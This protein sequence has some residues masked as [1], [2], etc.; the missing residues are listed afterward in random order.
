MIQSQLRANPSS[1][2][3]W[4]ESA[5]SLAGGMDRIAMG[6]LRV[7]LVIVLLWIGGLKFAAYEADSIVPF[8][9][10]SPM[11]R[12][13]YHH[14]NEYRTH[15]NKEGELK[16]QNRT[17]HRENKT[18]PV[19]RG[20]GAVEILIGLAIALFPVKPEISALG[21]ALIILM[22]CATLSFLI[23]T[24]EVWVPSLGD[25]SY[26][27][28]YL[29]GAGRLILKDCIM[30][31]AGFVTLADSAKSYLSGHAFTRRL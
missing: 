31:S 29:S 3:A 17:W 22:S 27:F 8:V 13:L 18:Y 11:M 26:G 4:L 14:P 16:P 12:F 30:L 2:A 9:A 20:I 7:S 10:N 28:P 15:M 19:S 1:P 5:L 23:T 24:P 25:A 6:M 21:S